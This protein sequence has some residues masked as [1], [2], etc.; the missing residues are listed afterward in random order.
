[1]L[2]LIIKHI[3]KGGENLGFSF[4]PEIHTRVP[5]CNE[6][7]HTL[8]ALDCLYAMFY[9]QYGTTLDLLIFFFLLL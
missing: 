7:I 2:L 3:A 5:K 4:P 6:N 9:W 8:Y 1:M